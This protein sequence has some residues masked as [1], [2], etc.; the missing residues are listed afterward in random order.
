MNSKEK[1]GMIIVLLCGAMWGLSGVLGEMLF[2]NSDITVEILSS[3]RM[4]F[5]GV[6]ILIF[7]FFREGKKIFDLWRNKDILIPFFVFSIF[8]LMSVQYTYFAAVNAANAATAT[9]LQYTYPILVLVCTSVLAKKSPNP[10]EIVAIIMAFLGVV[11]IATHGKLNSLTISPSALFWGLISAC[12]F[13]FYTMYPKKI[14]KKIGLLET[15]GW[16]FIVGGVVLLIVTNAYAQKVTINMNSS[17][18]FLLIAVFGTLVPFC[19]YGRG[20]EILGNIR[21]SLFV[22]VEPICSAILAFFILKTSFKIIDIVGFL[23]IISA[24]E[25]VAYKSLQ[26]SKLKNN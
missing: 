13:V 1:L 26:E 24:V 19:I 6:I 17:V 4:I 8:G 10:Y 7:L 9:V 20:V 5:S 15:M 18:I 22:T 12:C 14:Y 11:L 25:L 3:A 16:A 21:A 2:R 23:F